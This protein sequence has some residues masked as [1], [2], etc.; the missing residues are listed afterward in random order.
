MW[1]WASL[2]ISGS[3]RFLLC[4]MSII[5]TSHFFWGPSGAKALDCRWAVRRAVR[6]DLGEYSRFSLW[7]GF[8][9]AKETVS[10]FR[11][12]YLSTIMDTP[13]TRR[14]NIYMLIQT[15]NPFCKSNVLNFAKRSLG[16][17]CPPMARYQWEESTVRAAGGRPG[18]QL[19][20]ASPD[21]CHFFPSC[22]HQSGSPFSVVFLQLH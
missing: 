17:S 7:S 10:L 8:L 1:R 20:L 18:S 4:K 19:P 11:S 5:P 21:P 13:P 22:S 12:G 16:Q 3:L 6:P 9:Y 2:I 14:K 15:A